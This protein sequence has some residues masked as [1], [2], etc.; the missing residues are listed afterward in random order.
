MKTKITFILFLSLLGSSPALQ[1]QEDSLNTMNQIRNHDRQ[2]KTCLEK[3]QSLIEKAKTEKK[4][5]FELSYELSNL[6][7]Q[8]MDKPS[9]QIIMV[10]ETS[11]ENL[12]KPKHQ[13]LKQ[14]LLKKAAELHAVALEGEEKYLDYHKK[15][16]SNFRT[17]LMQHNMDALERHLT[18]ILLHPKAM[19]FL[20]NL[21]EYHI[22]RGEF[23]KA[24]ALFEI[25]SPIFNEPAH[26][27]QLS[28][29]LYLWLEI[30][31]FGKNP[32]QLEMLMAQIQNDIAASDPFR[33]KSEVLYEKYQSDE[34]E[35]TKYFIPKNFNVEDIHTLSAWMTVPAPSVPL[36][37]QPNFKAF[38]FQNDIIITH[39]S[40][41]IKAYDDGRL[42]LLAKAHGNCT[43]KHSD[44]LILHSLNNNFIEIF[45]IETK[46]LKVIPL[47]KEV[48]ITSTN[49]LYQKEEQKLYFTALKENEESLWIYDLKED[50]AYKPILFQLYSPLID[51][52]DEFIP[53]TLYAASSNQFFFQIKDHWFLINTKTND[54][55]MYE[56]SLPSVFLNALS[57]TPHEIHV[58]DTIYTIDEDVLLS[59]DRQDFTVY[60]LPSSHEKLEEVKKK[61][62]EIQ[63]SEQKL[64]FLVE[65]MG[66]LSRPVRAWALKELPQLPFPELLVL[67]DKIK[68]NKILRRVLANV[69]VVRELQ[70][71]QGKTLPEKCY[72]F[73]QDHWSEYSPQNK[74][75]ILG[76]FRTSIFIP[77]P[78]FEQ[79]TLFKKAFADAKQQK[80]KNIMSMTS[81]CLGPI[82][83]D[84]QKNSLPS[85]FER[86]LNSI[87]DLFFNDNG[88]V[89]I[90]ARP[91]S[92][93]FPFLLYEQVLE[94]LAPFLLTNS[95]GI[96]MIFRHAL[97]L[98]SENKKQR[99]NALG[100]CQ[101]LTQKAIDL[102]IQS[103]EAPLS[104]QAFKSWPELIET[105]IRQQWIN[106][107]PYEPLHESLLLLLLKFKEHP[108]FISLA[109][110]SAKR[111]FSTS[112]KVQLLLKNYL[113]AHPEEI[114]SYVEELCLELSQ[115]PHSWF[116]YELLDDLEPHLENEKNYERLCIFLKE[117]PNHQLAWK[118][119]W[120][121][122][123]DQKP[124]FSKMKMLLDIKDPEITTEIALY[125]LALETR[126]AYQLFLE[127]IWP[128]LELDQDKFLITILRAIKRAPT[129]CLS[130]DE[131]IKVFQ[132]LLYLRSKTATPMVLFYA[133]RELLALWPEWNPS[134]PTEKSSLKEYLRILIHNNKISGKN[135]L[136]R[137]LEKLD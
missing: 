68:D 53:R 101:S 121:L 98:M 31:L 32:T 114:Q 102:L 1:A 66:S 122:T 40:G 103:T 74:M 45:D 5:T 75:R 49:I 13:S 62:E 120:M 125:L 99:W 44:I 58:N 92:N 17:D 39:D 51:K 124:S 90:L 48:Q 87:C 6:M 4:R 23:G 117:N 73:I 43:T 16:E 83:L 95:D 77:I 7:D 29:V 28:K 128:T 52:T 21:I 55:S 64:D 60:V 14:Y 113:K 26:K 80:E 71:F 118:I 33:L 18:Q 36:P 37:R 134:D 112:E 24:Q 50:V 69:D 93:P 76:F 70:K 11:K 127:K 47:M 106:Q 3:T 59:L 107:D 34:K 108:N 130:I 89:D 19:S 91:V 94:T 22:E 42:H 109:L 41:S 129:T 131:K 10:E 65:Q 86:E 46:N 84:F 126:E 100:Q 9:Y 88:I 57:D 111:V 2:L 81:M 133:A 25:G 61:W 104:L 132:K 115:D 15:I 67:S 105:I 78:A 123:L 137:Q 72:S 35:R 135:E 38:A 110:D 96:E 30:S 56:H 116:G 20:M 63:E 97:L 79:L 85:E 136:S 27:K 12:P 119:R 54:I 82:L 8:I